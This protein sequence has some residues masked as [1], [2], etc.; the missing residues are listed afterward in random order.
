MNKH[1]ILFLLTTLGLILGVYS[2]DL[3]QRNPETVFLTTDGIKEYQEFKQIVPERKVAVFKFLVKITSH[4]T[5]EKKLTSV[6]TKHEEKFDFLLPKDLFP[7]KEK[8]K[9]HLEKLENEK[10]KIQLIGP[11]FIA[12]LAIEKKELT[13]FE[14]LIDDFKSA[15]DHKLIIAGIPY[16]NYLLD[17]YSSSIKEKVFPLMFSVSFIFIL[18][19][20]KSLLTSIFLFLPC[21]FSA[22][23]CLSFIKYFYT[24]MNMVTS[25]IP[26]MC[27][28][29]NLAMVFH[30][31]FTMRMTN[32]FRD[33]LKKK[34]PPITLMVMTTC[35]GFGSLMIS[36][37]EAIS[38]FGKL[39]LV[40][41]LLTSVFSGLFVAYSQ[42]YLLKNKKH[43]HDFENLSRFFHQSFKGKAIALIAVVSIGLGGFFLKRIEIITD[44]T[45]YFPVK[46]G[47]KKSIDAVND[48]VAGLPLY[49]IIIPLG[50]TK[51]ENI[52]AVDSMEQELKAKFKD[53]QGF[54]S[55]LSLSSM[56]RNANKEYA[57]REKIPDSIYAVQALRT[58]FKP[59][60]SESYPLQENYKLSLMGKALNVDQYETGLKIIADFFVSKNMTYK[61]NG[62]Y[63][64]LMISQKSMI[65]ILFKSFLLALLIVSSIAYLYL[66]KARIFF[67]FLFV[68]IVPVFASFI[69]MYLLG[70]SINIATVMTYSI[71]LGM[72]VDSSFHLVHNLKRR[73]V[74][75]FD[76]YFKTTVVPI[77]GSSFLFLGSFSLF[78]FNGFLPISQFGLN[79]SVILFLGLIFDLFILPTLFLGNHKIKEAFDVPHI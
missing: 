64:N 10:G 74:T 46:S 52:K 28:T 59:S 2:K 34:L 73:K 51:L 75:T 47:F 71:A 25:I 57:G 33:A 78:G 30:L 50:E 65:S 31:Y 8:F 18:L 21:L 13:E 14:G 62:L 67:I 48:S 77:L 54:H 76:E 79:L 24:T 26:L 53:F 58:K 17:Q 38:T 4:E 41:I 23:I 35:I 7:S 55:I 20:T 36:E 66:R 43:N 5:L 44:A 39:S 40:L 45:R 37:I 1:I 70:F 12:I 69:L 61:L 16:T 15:T 72:I 9:R 19:I 63:Y 6:L 11:N 60:I 22:V 49:D 42:Q 29:I 3:T 68:N 27:F 56:I 32:S